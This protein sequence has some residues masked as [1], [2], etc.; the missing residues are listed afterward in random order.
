MTALSRA[1]QVLENDKDF[2]YLHKEANSTTNTIWDNSPEEVVET[3]E[4]IPYFHEK[5]YIEQFIA[6]Y[7]I[8][9]CFAVAITKLLNEIHVEPGTG[10]ERYMIPGTNHLVN[11]YHSPNPWQTHFKLNAN[12]LGAKM[13]IEEDVSVSDKYRSNDGTIRFILVEPVMILNP[14]TATYNPKYMDSLVRV[15]I[16]TRP[17][18]FA[19]VHLRDLTISKLLSIIEMAHLL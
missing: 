18:A 11:I 1:Q 9:M 2:E 12:S 7:K 3:W 10:K 4:N 19:E 16:D 6:W 17:G 13:Y 15:E 14:V 8:A 5:M